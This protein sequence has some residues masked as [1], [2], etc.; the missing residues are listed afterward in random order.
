MIKALLYDLTTQELQQGGEELIQLW[1]DD[2]QTLIWL[3][4]S[5]HDAEREKALLTDTFGLHPL[6]VQDAQRERHPPKLETFKDHTFLL[7]KG[8]ADESRDFQFSTIQLAMF[9]GQ[10][11]L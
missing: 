9:I 7:L 8:L 2:R 1:L 3:D 6:A 4:F 11:F 5:E 10:R